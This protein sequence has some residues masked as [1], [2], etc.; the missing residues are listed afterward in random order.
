MQGNEACVL[1][2]TISP[3]SREQHKHTTPHGAERHRKRR[4]ESE[5]HHSILIIV[6]IFDSLDCHSL[7][8]C[9]LSAKMK[10]AQNLVGLLSLPPSPPFLL[11]SCLPPLHASPHCVSPF[12]AASLLTNPLSSVKALLRCQFRR[13]G[14]QVLF[15]LPARGEVAGATGLRT[16]SIWTG[17]HDFTLIY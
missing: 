8:H 17:R 10:Y 4:K 5:T 2:G 11:P 9:F 1:P 15:V 3:K 12:P 14:V 16:R 13:L 7:N 6:V